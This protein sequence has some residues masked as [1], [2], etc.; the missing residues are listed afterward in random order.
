MTAL[1]WVIIIMVVF[2]IA[3]GVAI[4]ILMT[5]LSKF[6]QRLKRVEDAA[7]MLRIIP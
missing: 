4:L 1:H 2:N 6:Q 7:Q 3:S 5:D